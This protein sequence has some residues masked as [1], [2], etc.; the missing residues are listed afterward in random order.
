MVYR[1]GEI[2]LNAV[3][4]VLL[5]FNFNIISYSRWLDY[6][7][8]LFPDGCHKTLTGPYRGSAL[9]KTIRRYTDGLIP[10]TRC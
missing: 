2:K 7:L 4:Q 9:V 6:C 10:A 5:Q 1:V 8:L 3:I